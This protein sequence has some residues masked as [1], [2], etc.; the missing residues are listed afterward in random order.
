[1]KENWQRAFGKMTNGIY[2]LT[3][4]YAEDINGMIASWATQVSHEPPLIAVAV[5]PN[6]YSHALIEKSKSFALHVV[7]H[8]RQ[9]IMDRMM[10]PDP[11]AKFSGIHWEPGQTGCPVLKDCLAWFECSVT[12]QLKPGNHT[13]FFG[14]VV[15]AGFV[16]PGRPLCTFDCS[17]VYVGKA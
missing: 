13:L 8:T 11:A 7:P 17:G 12:R 4:R 16:S 2:V 1:M 15:N 10:G 5:H 14:Q 6:R 3:T 9:E